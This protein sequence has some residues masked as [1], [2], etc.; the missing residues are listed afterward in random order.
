MENKEQK[1]CPLKK[2]YN[3]VLSLNFDFSSKLKHFLFVLLGLVLV[4]TLVTALFGFKASFELGGGKMF[5]VSFDTEI[6]ESQMQDYKDYI[7]NKLNDNNLKTNFVTTDGAGHTNAI[8]V[9]FINDN[10][11]DSELATLFEEL[12]QD[13][14][15]ELNEG[16][17]YLG[18]NISDLYNASPSVTSSTIWFGVLALS[19]MLVVYLLYLFI[20][21]DKYVLLAGFV[22][23][24][25]DALMVMATLLLFRVRISEVI[26]FSIALVLTYSFLLTLMTF[27]RVREG[28][29]KQQ[30]EGYTNGKI[31]NEVVKS[32]VVRNDILSTLMLIFGVAL[33]PL[34]A[35][36][37]FELGVTLMIIALAVDYSAVF[38]VPSVWTLV[39][40]RKNDKRL[41]NRL[42]ALEKEGQKVEEKLIV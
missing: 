5:V 25:H 14:E 35:Y 22:G 39:Y 1:V 15:A 40:N 6:T 11:K 29:V 38:I 9:K 19:V 28:F 20:R 24:M 12:S 10:Y 2:M 26:F 16:E 17:Q 33:L 31:V 13:I 18:F 23:M 41:N 7:E 42:A 30:F 3:K 36:Y 37:G 34:G 32:G 21:F 8:V 27:T 4:A